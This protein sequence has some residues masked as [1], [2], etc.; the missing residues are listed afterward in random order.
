MNRVTLAVAAV[1]LAPQ[2]TAA[3]DGARGLYTGR[4]GGG[5][6]SMCLHLRWCNNAMASRSRE[7]GP[8]CC[9]ILDHIGC[10]RTDGTAVYSRSASTSVVS[11]SIICGMPGMGSSMVGK[12]S[13]RWRSPGRFT[14]LPFCWWLWTWRR[15][16]SLGVLSADR[17]RSR[18]RIPF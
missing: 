3:I 4:A 13:C 17:I 9:G 8:G 15:R 14:P 16:F 12:V 11:S 10:G 18:R 1:G 2:N 7:H 5:E 6:R